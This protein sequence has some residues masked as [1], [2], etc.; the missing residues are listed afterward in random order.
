MPAHGTISRWRPFLANDLVYHVDGLAFL[1]AALMALTGLASVTLG[2]GRSEHS[3]SPSHAALLAL[4]VAG[5]SFV[6]SANLITLCLSWLVLDL[7]F[8]GALTASDRSESRVTSASGLEGGRPTVTNR[9]APRVLRLSLLACLSLLAAALLLGHDGSLGDL[10]LAPA[11]SNAQGIQAERSV[12]APV[13]GLILLAALMRVGLY[14]LNLWVPTD[15][16]ASLPARSQ[17]HLVPASVG[18]YLLTRLS[19]WTGDVPGPVLS[20][21]EVTSIGGG[22]PYGQVLAIAG[23]LAILVGALLAWAETDLVKS[24]SFI[25]VSQVGYVVAS[26]AVAPPPAM[27]VVLLS[28]LNAILCLGLLFLSLD[29]SELGS[30]WARAATGL[31]IASLTGVPLTMGF[32]GRW[33]H[34]QFLLT[35]GNLAYLALSLLAEAFLFAAL[36]R[37]WSASSIRVFPPEFAYRSSSVVGAGLLAVPLL[38]LGFYPPVLRPLMETDS[39][40]SVADLLRST[41]IVQWTVLLLPLLAGYLLRSEGFRHY[42]RRIFDPAEDSWPKLTAALRLEWLYDLIGGIIDRT[43]GALRIVGGVSEDS[44]YLGWIIVLGLLA[45][46]FLRGG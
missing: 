26:L 42:R 23:C 20:S 11:L 5:F 21:V 36:L 44:G 2:L 38:I 14:P 8:L 10:D 7:A 34:Y 4:L 1:F 33:H 3:D 27:V 25:V 39:F 28:S 12:S 24:L 22:L 19:V 41:G 16:D 30:L 6:F 40:P 32:V 37:V 43:A 18:V 29:R 35:G 9:I 13:F 15:V 46:L 31:A 17:L 45:S